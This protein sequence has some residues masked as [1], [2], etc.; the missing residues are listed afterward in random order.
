MKLFSFN[1]IFF[2]SIS[3]S[4]FCQQTLIHPKEKIKILLLGTYHFANPGQDKFNVKV[5]DYF[6]EHRQKE[7]QEVNNSLAKFKPEKIFTEIGVRFQPEVDEMYQK[8]KSGKVELTKGYVNEKFQIGLKLARQ[9]NN[10]RFYGV[11]AGG[12]WFEDKVKRYADSTGMGFY[13]AFEKA[14]QNHVEYLNNY[15]STHTVKQ[16][17]L[18][19]NSKQEQLEQNHYIYNYILSRVGAGDNY[20]GADLVGEWY[21]RNLRIYSNILK[22]VDTEKDKRLLVIFGNGHM[23][24][25]KQL[26]ED[27]PD[28]EVVDATKFL[29]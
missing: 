2:L 3:L 23:H 20:I 14:T 4:G 10:E 24:I 5:D 18:L 6:S 8:F 13:A 17:L 29:K 22:F 25:L 28:F 7:I 11:D 9:L 12:L 21:K 26:F 27:N 19:L 15:F 1:I 16:N